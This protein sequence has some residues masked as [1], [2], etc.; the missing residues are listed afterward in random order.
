MC[1]QWAESIAAPP[2]FI[3]TDDDGVAHGCDQTSTMSIAVDRG[4]ES[5]PRIS[6]PNAPSQQFAILP[7]PL[8]YGPASMDAPWPV[9]ESFELALPEHRWLQLR[10]PA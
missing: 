7:R 5:P 4:N 10:P 3:P 1:S 6:T 8:V 2:P 9:I